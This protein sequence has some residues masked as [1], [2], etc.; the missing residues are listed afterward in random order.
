MEDIDRKEDKQLGG[1][2]KGVIGEIYLSNELDSVSSLEI[3][4][5]SVS[6]LTA[7]PLRLKSS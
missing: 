7:C 3:K 5:H 6:R 2:G 4:S 1:K